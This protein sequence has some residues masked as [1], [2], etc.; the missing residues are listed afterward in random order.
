M[1]SA[2]QGIII[3]AEFG[4]GDIH[5]DEAFVMH[6]VP[7]LSSVADRTSRDV[8]RVHELKLFHNMMMALEHEPDIMVR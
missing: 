2:S 5:D 1:S 6:E 4:A 7:V 8:G 3:P